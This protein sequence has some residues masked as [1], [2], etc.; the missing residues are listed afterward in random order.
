MDNKPIL[1]ILTFPWG[2]KTNYS[3]D[4][5]HCRPLF[6]FY[7]ILHFPTCKT[8]HH[9]AH[10]PQRIKMPIT[11]PLHS[12]SDLYVEITVPKDFDSTLYHSLS[13]SPDTDDRSYD[14]HNAHSAP[15]PVRQASQS[16]SV[17]AY[18]MG[19]IGEPCT[20]SEADFSSPYI[21]VKLLTNL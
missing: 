1:P 17:N 13:W 5:K 20:A 2:S 14:P 8:S 19:Y 11:H 21:C 16:I 15:T 18:E 10:T 6:L 4:K 3:S 7:I 12:V 9:R